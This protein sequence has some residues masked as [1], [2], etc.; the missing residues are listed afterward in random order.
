MKNGILITPEI[1]CKIDN[2]V[3]NVLGKKIEAFEAIKIY[4]ETMYDEFLTNIN[5]NMVAQ[6]LQSTYFNIINGEELI[7][8]NGEFL[9]ILKNKAD[10]FNQTPTDKSKTNFF[11][12]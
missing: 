7:P 12:L 1:D 9:E 8:H 10:M 11:N 5:E 6:P 2:Y 3:S 4:D